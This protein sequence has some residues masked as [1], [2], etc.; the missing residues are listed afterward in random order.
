MGIDTG[1]YTQDLEAELSKLP[2]IHGDGASPPYASR[3][4][5]KIL[6]AA[7]DEAKRFNDEYTGVEHIYIALLKEHGTSS[8]QMIFKKYGVYA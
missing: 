1:A 4:F 3:R 7:Q 8:Q 2:Q 5:N 6:I